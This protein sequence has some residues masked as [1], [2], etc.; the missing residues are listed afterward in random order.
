MNLSATRTA[1]AAGAGLSITLLVA[2]PVWAD[3]VEL[4]LS[5][6]ASSDAAKPNILFIIDS[7]G[8]MNTKET[9]Q[10]PFTAG[11][12]YSGGGCDDD[13]YYWTTGSSIP[14]CGSEYRIKKTAFLCEQGRTQILN[15]GS[16]V[17]TMAQYRLNKK[18]KRKWRP[19]GRTNSTNG[20][21]CKADSGEHGYG[22]N[23][24]DE[25]Y[26][27]A[28][29]DIDP[30]TADGN[31]EV[32]WGVRPTHQIVT[33][34]D[35]N[36]L[37][38]FHNPP[39]TTARRT[40]IVKA[41]TKN[42]LGSIRD[43]NVGVMQ[44]HYVEGGVV[45]HGIK[46]L[47][48]NR[49][50]VNSIV[51]GIPAEGAT[52]LAETLYEAALYWRGMDGYY[53]LRG[54]DL[55]DFESAF[56]DGYWFG[57]DPAATDAYDPS[58]N[59][60]D[61]KQPAEFACSKNFV[62]LLTDGEPVYDVGTYD[63]V[64]DL[65]G[66]GRA[67]C[68]SITGENDP[69]DDG[70]CLDDVADYLQRVDINPG[71]P[72]K[73]DVATYTIG[74]KLDEELPLLADTAARGGGEYY[75]AEDVKSLTA[76]LTDIVTDI[77]DRD[78]SFTA[79][80][81]AV[82][83]FNRTQHLNDLYVSVFRATDE[84]HWPGNMKKYT[85]ADAEIQDVKGDPAVN[86]DTG[87]F[88]DNARNFW[89]TGA[90]NDGANV[91]DGGVANI[92]PD[93]ASRKL[94]TNNSLGDLTQSSNH[95]ST[96]NLG[97]YNAADFGLTGA[98]GEPSLT[99]IIEWARGVD[100]Q[101]EDNNPDT[102]IRYAMGDTLHSQPAAV[103]YGDAQGGQSVY[104]FNATNDGYLH[105]IDADTGKEIWSWIPK[106]LLPNLAD[107]YFNEN[108]DYKNY[109]IDGDVIPV[110][111]D[112][113]E[114]GIIDP[115]K[116]FVYIVFGMRRG[117][118]NY[119]MVDVTVPS[120]P[121]LKWIRTF[122]EFGQSWSAPVVARI[123]VDSNDQT[124]ALDAV[125]VLGGGYD[126]THDAPAHP[127]SPDLEGAGVHMLDLDTGAMV[128]RAG[129]DSGAHLSLTN[130]TRAIPSRIRVIDLDGDSLADRMYA[131]DL[132]GQV[133][134]FDITNG[135][136]TDKLVAG[137][138]IAQLGAEGLSNPG[139][140]DTRRFYNTPDVSMFVD[141]HQERR[142][143]AI[144][145]G[146]G[147]RAH[148]LDNSASDAFFSLRDPAVFNKLTQ[149]Q[150]NSYPVIRNADLVEVAGK[151][152]TVIPANGDGWKFTLP[153]NEKILADSQTFDDSVYFVSFEPQISSSDPCQ[154]GLSVNRL[155]RLNVS[156]GDPVVPDDS[157]IPITDGVAA[158]DARIMELEQ[159]GIAP[160]PVFYFPS[161]ADPK[162][163]GLDCKPRPVACVGV[164]CF[165]PDFDP[166]PVRTLWTQNG[167]E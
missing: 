16:Y 102:N 8:S 118:D 27:Q 89:K 125:L 15:A 138:V 33:M 161:P 105:A 78:I 82:N 151:F 57:T 14:N 26:A 144:G 35:S 20:V 9:Y 46:D 39:T 129:R 124:N 143:L 149:Q 147:Y 48:D 96:A 133:W 84:V 88:A 150:F 104:V 69:N 95:L 117:G 87:F 164:E 65:P 54:N 53:G 120:K 116:D 137:G 31:R 64:P 93:P 36:Y 19:I 163:I 70:V 74:F 81:V 160:K 106:E 165:D 68:N 86:P 94:Y 109:G 13:Y 58:D 60:L 126:T 52:P 146:S 139:A 3:D 25:P 83:A 56:P 24:A 156:N 107:L 166:R 63:R 92:L 2:S 119:Y 79:P 140:A 59:I 61:Y 76:A 142:Y 145:V 154:A 111:Y 159:G 28:G 32:D 5:T 153:P 123:E 90:G 110:V 148:P 29:T 134:R 121:I 112:E 10:E 1:W 71:L 62:V 47:D 162:C 18:G 85:I 44:F 127:T 167:I 100:V 67:S 115:T 22:S 6:P 113:N 97:A 72:G 91:N 23:P 103:V 99:Q 11:K 42:V 98:A 51:D 30:Y 128:W 45:I 114:D 131:V 7:S 17:D 101:D 108:V 122:P 4:L 50:A 55:G 157:S 21:E 158:D 37:S 132:G 49:S 38:W 77:F 155:Y 12:D 41:V 40:D 80:A 141:N 135:E 130:M 66:F 73:Q 152:D 136:K 34:Y 43:V 75:P